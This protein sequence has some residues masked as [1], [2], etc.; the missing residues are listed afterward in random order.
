MKIKIWIKKDRSKPRTLDTE[1]TESGN[2]VNN[3]AVRFP[4]N[5]VPG[6]EL[7]KPNWTKLQ[8]A[9]ESDRPRS[10]S[11]DRATENAWGRAGGGGRGKHLKTKARNLTQLEKVYHFLHPFDRFPCRLPCFSSE[12][13]AAEGNSNALAPRSYI[14]APA[15]ANLA[16]G[17]SPGNQ[18]RCIAMAVEKTRDC[19]Q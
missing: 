16:A 9:T 18:E 7:R 3:D 6:R 5:C 4:R 19:S 10:G 13:P 15:A 2:K 12:R 14:S 8:S 17:W 1:K 11:R